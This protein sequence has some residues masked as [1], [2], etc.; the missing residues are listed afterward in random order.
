MPGLKHRAARQAAQSLTLE[1]KM[2]PEHLALIV[3]DPSVAPDGI[4]FVSH[5][6]RGRYLGTGTGQRAQWL[7]QN[8]GKWRYLTVEES[9]ALRPC[10]EHAVNAAAEVPVSPLLTSNARHNTNSPETAML[11]GPDVRSPETGPRGPVMRAPQPGSTS[12][13]TMIAGRPVLRQREAAEMVG[14]C[15]R[16]LQRWS[17]R[18][19]GPPRTKIGGR[20]YYDAEELTAWARAN[21]TAARQQPRP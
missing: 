19:A 10:S 18:N 7:R 9:A 11:P 5:L 21:R 15:T 16:T 20:I 4:E 1:S 8:P 3:F 6:D 12:G 17:A 14:V 13:E 2:K